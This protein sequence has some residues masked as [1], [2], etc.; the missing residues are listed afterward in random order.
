MSEELTKDEIIAAQAGDIKHLT[1]QVGELKRM[2]MMAPSQ[3]CREY[4]VQNCHACDRIDCGDNFSPWKKEIDRLRD[5]KAQLIHAIHCV[6][7][8]HG[9]EPSGMI[10]QLNAVL[11]AVG[12]QDSASGGDAC[13]TQ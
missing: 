4:G 3:I 12:D 11:K 10:T 5:D 8:I 13:T 6:I 7:H 9:S 1:A 2:T